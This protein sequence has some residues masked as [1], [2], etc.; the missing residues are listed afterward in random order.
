MPRYAVIMSGRVKKFG[1]PRSETINTLNNYNI[2]TYR[3]DLDYSIV[4]EFS[5]NKG[6]FR[7]TK[8]I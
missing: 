5:K 2:I 6:N 7:K 1:F 8:K 4:Y 3:T